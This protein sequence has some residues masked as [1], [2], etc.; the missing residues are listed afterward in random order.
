[1]SFKYLSVRI[2]LFLFALTV[3]FGKAD[4]VSLRGID[5][6]IH[7][8]VSRALVSGPNVLVPAVPIPAV[9]EYSWGEAGARR[10]VE[11]ERRLRE[12]SALTPPPPHIFNDHPIGFFLIN[13]WVMKAL[14]ASF[15]SARLA[16]AVSGALAVVMVFELA[17]AL[18][19]PGV[20][21]VAALVFA[22]TR[23]FVLSAAAVSLDPPLVFLILLSFVLWLRGRWWQASLV[24]GLGFWVKT[25]VCLL[26]FPSMVFFGWWQTRKLSAFAKPAAGALL[27]LGVGALHWLALIVLTGSSDIVLDYWQ[28]QLGGTLLHGRGGG[29]LDPL[30]FPRHILKSFWPWLPLAIAG[31][32]TTLR[33][34]SRLGGLAF[35][36]ILILWFTFAPM[37]SLMSHYFLP[38]L[39]FLALL[40]AIP[41]QNRLE[42]RL[43]FVKQ[44]LLALTLFVLSI[45]ALTPIPFAPEPFPALRKFAPYIRQTG[46]CDDEIVWVPGGEPR[47]SVADA[48]MWLNF[49]TARAVVTLSCEQLRGRIGE[50]RL[51]W[52]IVSDENF[53][54][55]NA[56]KAAHP[57]FRYQNQWLL[58]FAKGFDRTVADL[59]PLEG[60]TQ[61]EVRCPR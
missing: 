44:V 35:S 43:P 5:S 8:T 17:L 13:G 51:R 36:V 52:V 40:A 28:G 59:R 22:A 10:S 37:T 15:W 16:T 54:G 60:G 48:A 38:A 21:I 30:F 53:R 27:A 56:L 39:P 34:R 7:A 29:R 46:G 12:S 4:E 49:V 2:L 61:I 18:G 33:T 32:V 9:N 42:Q 41:F 6:N 23:E 26:L 57:L 25:P 14:G 31:A 20:G 55:C 24:A 47:G 45:A 1:M 58:G 3:F 19:A 11:Q 50:A